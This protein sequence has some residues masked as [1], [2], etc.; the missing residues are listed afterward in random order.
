MG[1]AFTTELGGAT[2]RQQPTHHGGTL[3]H[4]RTPRHSFRASACSD[5]LTQPDH[6]TPLYIAF[7]KNRA[8][9]K[10]HLGI[11]EKFRR[12]IFDLF[13]PKSFGDP[14]LVDRGSA[15]FLREIF[16]RFPTE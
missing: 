13:S 14:G 15:N 16:D 11:F 5:A 12:E 10:G 2:V 6:Q 1:G 7:F 9:K 3:Q 4:P 8:N